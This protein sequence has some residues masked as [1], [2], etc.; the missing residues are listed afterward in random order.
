MAQI[1]FIG[2][3]SGLVS[4]LL[5]ASL[6]S[7]SPLAVV[8][9]YLAPLPVFIVSLG[10]PHWA[11]IIAALGGA[12][13]LA[14]GLGGPLG[15]VFLLGVGLPAWWLSYLALLASPQPDGRVDWYPLGRLVLWSAAIGAV[16]T[17][18]SLPLLTGSFEDYDAGFRAA[19]EIVLRSQLDTPEGAPIE[20]PNGGDPQRFLDLMVLLLP[21]MAALST[22]LSLLFNLWAG[23]RIV[24]RSARLPRPWPDIAAT[25]NFPRGTGIALAILLAGS[26]LSGVPGLFSELGAVTLVAAFAL[27]GFAVLHVLTRGVPGRS[28]ILT[29]AYF[30][31]LLQAWLIFVALLGLAEQIA[32]VRARVA[33]RRAGKSPPPNTT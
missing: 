18:I 14:V 31:V 22:M 1:F 21:P 17:A 16:L 5:F 13:A 6:A 25:L 3:G 7:G 19:L 27:L 29:A 10:W 2:L 23:A 9:F 33:A 24:R 11:G 28:F 8:L 4:A 15:L 20:L 12:A 26:W 32:G 30:L